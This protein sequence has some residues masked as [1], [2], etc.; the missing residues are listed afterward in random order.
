MVVDVLL[1]PPISVTEVVTAFFFSES[2]EYVELAYVDAELTDDVR[3]DEG[4]KASEEEVSVGNLKILERDGMVNLDVDLVV[5]L[6][7]EG[8]LLR[9]RILSDVCG[10]EPSKFIECQRGIVVMVRVWFRR[11]SDVAG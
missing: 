1:L 2:A 7:L 6:V 9:A 4:E 3:P 8:F 11:R 10:I 5:V